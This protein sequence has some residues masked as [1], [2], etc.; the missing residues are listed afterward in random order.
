VTVAILGPGAVGGV[1]TAGLMQSGVGVICIARPDTADLIGSEG[2]SLRQGEKV[3]KV[4]PEV[5]TELREPV[6]LLLV[7]VKAPSLED[8]LGRVSEPAQTVVPLL[9]GI[10]HM[11]T[12]RDHLPGSAVVA[13]TIG[14]IE[15]YL[16]R[17]GVVVQPTPGVVMTVAGDVDA[18]TVGLLRQ[19]GVEVRVNGGEAE[20]LWEKLA[21][22]APVA[23]ATALT[24]RRI[25]D[26]RSDPEW[27][28]RLQQAIVEACSVAAGDG[29][30]LSADAQ[31]E[32]IEAM[33]PLLTSS[34][35]RDVAAGRPS[36]LDAIT[37]AA[38]RAAHRVG[39]AAPVLEELFAEAEAACRPLLR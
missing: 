26:L 7:A 16:E 13:A 30:T 28:S 9:N 18:A 1:L 27:R 39:V 15:A 32:I 10:E 35:A 24:Q 31:W 5:T 8:A 19:S 21:R 4:R 29:V 12:L 37:G 34:T 3:Q 36:E 23:A 17:Q 6:E 22:Q 25:G 38:V 2:L 14:R 11:Q 20:V 33:P